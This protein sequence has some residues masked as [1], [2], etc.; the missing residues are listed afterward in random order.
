MMQLVPTAADY[1]R[2]GGED[3]FIADSV[4]GVQ[5]SLIKKA[6]NEAGAWGTECSH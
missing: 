5:L 4:T 1:S 6:L 2:G 3:V